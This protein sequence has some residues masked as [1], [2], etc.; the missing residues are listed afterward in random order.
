MQSLSPLLRAWGHRRHELFLEVWLRICRHTSAHRARAGGSASY[1]ESQE[2]CLSRAGA[3]C[4]LLLPNKSP[5]PGKWPGPLCLI[6]AGWGRQA[7]H[8]AAGGGQKGQVPPNGR[9]PC[10]GVG[11]RPGSGQMPQFLT[12][13]RNSTVA[14][15]EGH[16]GHE[17][18]RPGD[19]GPAEFLPPPR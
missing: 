19:K 18:R 10:P 17:G 4:R 8:G 15:Q 11:G 5:E 7:M 3:S 12:R 9:R 16:K 2:R 1:P 6:L 13:R 14:E